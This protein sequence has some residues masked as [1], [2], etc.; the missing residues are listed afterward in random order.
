MKSQNGMADIIRTK[1]LS[2]FFGK[3]NA[4]PRRI[5]KFYCRNFD[6]KI[7]DRRI[8]IIYKK[9][10]PVL[11]CNRG[12]YVSDNPLEVDEVVRA[13]TSRKD[14]IEENIEVLRQHKAYL[15]HRQR[16]RG[17]SQGNLFGEAG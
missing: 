17:M 16:E 2:D 8:R 14:A 10:I 9:T 15:I 7:S 3:E 13:E 4:K 5:L 12:I 6:P 11:W 1:L